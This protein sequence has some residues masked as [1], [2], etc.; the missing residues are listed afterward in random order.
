MPGDI[1]YEVFF[2]KNRK[3]GWT[4]S[5]ARDDRDQA[6]RLAHSLIAKQ[7]DAS[8]RV[9]KETF[10]KEHRKFRSVPIF[11]GGAETMGVEKEKTGEARLPCL[12]P[13]DLSKPHARD[14]IRRVLTNW[15]E[16]VQAIPME[17]L[18][19]PDLV[20]NL[21][22]S[23]TELQHA[24]QKVAIAS[25]SDSDA[26][27]HGYVKQLNELVQK[28][29]AR[30]YKDGRDNRLPE[31]PKKA[32]FADIAGEIH[33][34]DRRAYS[35]RAAM[36]DRLR[37]EK[38]YGDKLEALLDMGDSLPEAEDARNF[39]LDEVDHYIAE[40]IAFDAGREA[41]LGKCKD[42][43]ETLERLACLFDGDHSADALNLAPSAAKRLAKKIK[44]RALPAC[45]A[46]I[47]ANILK[48]LERPK[49]L[50]PTSVR[51]EVRLARDLA[52][53]LVICADST[54]PADA[55]I[56]AFASRSARLL[57]PEIIDELLRHSRGAD[58]DLDRLIALEENLVGEANKQ[59]LA[60]YIR[61][62]LG[63]PNA[64]AWYVRGDAK[65]LERLAKLTAQQA[66]ILKGKYPERDKLELAANFD[67]LGM[68]IV[69]DSKIL[70]MVEAGDRPA[71][72]KATGLLRLATG[73]A[74]PIGNCSADAQARALRHLKSAVGLSEAQAED[75]RPKLRQIQGM[76]QELSQRQAKAS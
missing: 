31:Y 1:H 66:K 75:G 37:H 9:T 51:D 47:A 74:L 71:L 19:R 62:T 59:K 25:A 44:G 73:G 45:R 29:L 48:D 30:I 3:S 58:E 38:K 23:G 22:A 11:E 21:E 40:V 18:H 15:L 72:D 68:K 34:R 13:D 17:L 56:K 12:T 55:L 69:D 67:A 14:T 61:S 10:D 41:L 36:A 5:E 4:L 8:V 57:Q 42:L 35:L 64:D 33:K 2:K 6:I 39:A 54:L 53:R 65:P 27:V 7:K 70:N 32:N 28:S 26:G 16:R 46:A 49:R 20:E 76:L 24:V 60:G 43:G 52:S 63:S 50:R